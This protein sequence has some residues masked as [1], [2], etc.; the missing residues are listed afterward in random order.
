[1]LKTILLMILLALLGLFGA[2]T[3]VQIRRDAW[4]VFTLIPVSLASV[5]IWMAQVKSKQSLAFSS[6]L[7]D[8]VYGCS[9]MVG[10]VLLG[11]AAGWKQVLGMALAVIGLTLVGS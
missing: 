8:L 3:S 11:E 5:C 6:V 7:F 4:P 9:Y 1:M 2:Y 10:F